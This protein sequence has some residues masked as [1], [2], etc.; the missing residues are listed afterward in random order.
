MIFLPKV[1]ASILDV[2]RPG[3]AKKVVKGGLIETAPG[4]V[5]TA[6]AAYK[7][8]KA[9]AKKKSAAGANKRAKKK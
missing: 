2:G 8:A 5:S 9:G 7:V 1:E 3:P 4:E 6:T